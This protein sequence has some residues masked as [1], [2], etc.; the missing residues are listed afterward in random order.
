MN[1][2]II[3]EIALIMMFYLLY[4]QP[5]FRYYFM[6]TN[7]GQLLL[8]LL[9]ITCYYLDKYLGVLFCF[10]IV[11]VHYTNK[12]EGFYFYQNKKPD[13]DSDSDLD[14][15]S[16]DGESVNFKKAEKNFRKK[17]CKDNT[18]KYKGNIVKNEMVEHVFPEINFEGA[19]CNP[20]DD[21]CKYDFVEQE[22]GQ[23]EEIH[24][25]TMV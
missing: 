12:Q 24:A 17:N 14:S 21:K 8:L 19:P 16:E 6:E 3:G 1:K 7:L 4:W 10:M 13:S 20:C 18:L 23:E 15:E 11:F 9:F 22:D 25:S 5:E 2:L